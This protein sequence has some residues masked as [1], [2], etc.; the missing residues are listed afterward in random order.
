MLGTRGVRLGLLHPEIY[1][2]Q[3]HAIF[4]AAKAVK[5]S[6]GGEMPHLEL[7]IPLVAYEHELSIMREVAERVGGEHGFTHGEDYSVGTMIELPRACAIAKL[8]A[9]EADFFSFGTNDLTQ[10]ALGFSRDD[11][12][13]KFLDVYL[14]RK[15]P[16]PVAVRDDRRAGR[17]RARAHGG[18]DRARG[19]GRP[20]ARHLRRARRRPGLDR[21]SST[22]TGSTTCPAPRS[23]C[24]SPAWRRRRRRSPIRAAAGPADRRPVF[25]PK[26][27]RRGGSRESGCDTG[28][29]VSISVESAFAERMRA[30]EAATLSPLATPSYPAVRAAAGG[31]LLP[32]HAVPAR[33]RPDRALQDVPAAQAQD[34]GLRGAG[35]R[36]LPHAAHAHARGHR[37]L[38][39]GRAGAAAQ[40]GPH[41]GDR[42]SGTTS[43]TRRSGTSARTSWT[44]AAASA[45]G[46]GSATT[47]TP[48][49]WSTCSRTST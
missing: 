11:A 26:L 3:F 27:R 5:E 18:V 44:A 42:A 39:H 33:P 21:R 9:L 16:R 6:K 29:A 30:L 19:E 37:D 8:I 31:R 13:G 38:A 43:A 22:A 34:A 46:A 47:S 12:E 40:R 41:G 15:D 14:E 35:G 49:G 4:L 23:A 24:R 10:T 45:S 20:Q 36:P 25:A 32:A 28:R 7:M 2:M 17:R 1:E 48:C